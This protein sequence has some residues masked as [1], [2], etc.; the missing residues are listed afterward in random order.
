[1]QPEVQKQFDARQVQ[2]ESHALDDRPDALL[3]HRQANRAA[4][5]RDHPQ[6]PPAGDRQM[7][8]DQPHQL[9]I[10][11]SKHHR[12]NLVPRLREGLRRHLTD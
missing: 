12:T 8:L 11:R 1:M 9:L 2:A 5:R 6:P 7:G 4:I 3:H 10:D